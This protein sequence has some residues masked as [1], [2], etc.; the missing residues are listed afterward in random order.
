MRIVVPYIT[1]RDDAQHVERAER[2]KPDG[3]VVKPA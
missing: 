1:R 3:V 2:M